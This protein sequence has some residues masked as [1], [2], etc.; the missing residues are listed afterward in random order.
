MKTIN[1]IIEAYSINEREFPERRYHLSN[2]LSIST[3][4]I[5]HYKVFSSLSLSSQVALSA[6]L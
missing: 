5:S 4:Y 1:E 6:L 3:D 2:V